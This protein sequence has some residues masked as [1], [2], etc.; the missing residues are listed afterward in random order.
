MPTNPESSFNIK[1][2]EQEAKMI[3]SVREEMDADEVCK[4]KD[5]NFEIKKYFINQ[6]Q[7]KCL[8]EQGKVFEGFYKSGSYPKRFRNEH[9][10]GLRKQ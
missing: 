4:F 6:G 10:D 7:K 5:F 8:Q 9:L 1:T 3:K 2:Q